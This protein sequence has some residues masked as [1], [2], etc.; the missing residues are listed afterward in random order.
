MESSERIM[1]IDA[2]RGFAI[3]LVVVGHILLMRYWPDGDLVKKYIYSFHMP[4]F[5][6]ISGF[7]AKKT[8]K[9]IS[10]R[11]MGDYLKRKAFQLMMPFCV[12]G[13]ST[14]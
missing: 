14:S 7:F 10:F 2:L 9:F 13:V 8:L 1:W 11:A 6:L 3:L 4:L 12:F 5:M